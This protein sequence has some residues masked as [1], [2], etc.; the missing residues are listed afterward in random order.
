MK[1]VFCTTCK[2]RTSHLA[3]TLPQ[4][5]RDNPDATF[6]VLDYNDQHDLAGYINHNHTADIE[7]GRLVVYHYREP[8]PFQM[9]HAKN[10]VHRLGILEG[11]DVLVNQDADNFTGSGFS[12]YIRE[13][14]EKAHNSFLWARMVK[15]GAQR[16][17]RGIS[18]RIVVSKDAFILAGG[19]D[20]KYNVHS[21]DDKDFNARLQRLG[22]NRKEIDRQFLNVILHTDRLRFREYPHAAGQFTEDFYIDQEN[23]VVN[24]GNFGCGLVWRNYQSDPVRLLPVPTRIFGIGMHKTATTSLHTALKRLGIKSGHWVTAHWAK[25]I[26]RE[27]NTFGRS[28]TM[29]QYYAV[30]DLPITMLFRQLDAGYPGAKFILTLRD[31]KAWLASVR[32]HWSEEHNE[33]RVRWDED[34]FSHRVHKLLYGRADFD[35]DIMLARYRLHTV[36]VMEHFKDRPDDLLVMHMDRKH[37]WGELCR[38]LNLPIPDE[39]YPVVYTYP[40]KIK[41]T[42]NEHPEGQEL[43]A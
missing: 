2:G 39:P 6:V 8:G 27:M 3:R 14:F 24:A 11:G 10:M 5:L 32:K 19:Y 29:E 18:G 22:F 35:P 9:A 36:E 34:P 13:H 21:P 1:I 23:T 26:W 25:A 40:N 33:H 20:E 43:S 42:V 38:F 16:L 37:G 7:S 4:N 30:N 31:E 17:P 41:E 12:A 15:E 28:P